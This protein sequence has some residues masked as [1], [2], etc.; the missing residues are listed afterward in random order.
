MATKHIKIGDVDSFKVVSPLEVIPDDRQELV[1]TLD[2]VYV[3][4]NGYLEN[5]SKMQGTIILK[6]ADWATVK[7]YWTG[8]TLVN[9]LDQDDNTYLNCRVKVN[10]YKHYSIEFP[11]HWIITFELW[12]I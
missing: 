6:S 10:S 2:G 3:V 7:G 12:R 8:R 5:G 1:K 4:D 9:V 11:N